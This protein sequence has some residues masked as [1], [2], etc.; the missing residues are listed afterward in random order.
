MGW[1]ERLACSKET[2]PFKRRQPMPPGLTLVAP[3][4]ATMPDAVEVDGSE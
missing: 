1:R 2:T 4:P 3:A